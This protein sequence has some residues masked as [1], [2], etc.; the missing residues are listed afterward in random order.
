LS[1]RA[2]LVKDVSKLLVIRLF[3][4]EDGTGVTRVLLSSN[5]KL[6]DLK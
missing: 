4:R 5:D 2:Y 3:G 6:K 1:P